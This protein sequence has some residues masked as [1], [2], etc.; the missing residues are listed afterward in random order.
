MALLL[1]EQ[2]RDIESSKRALLG[3]QYYY[4][5]AALSKS[6]A[7]HQE[8]GRRLLLGELSLE[9]VLTHLEKRV[10]EE[11]THLLQVA[12]KFDSTLLRAPI[13]WQQSALFPYQL[14]KQWQELVGQDLTVE[15]NLSL[16]MQLLLNLRALSTLVADHS[17]LVLGDDLVS[18]YLSRIIFI[19]IPTLQIQLIDTLEHSTVFIKNSLENIGLSLQRASQSRIDL[20]KELELKRAIAGAEEQLIE[21]V[22]RLLS[23]RGT[24]IEALSQSALFAKLSSHQLE[25]FLSKDLYALQ[26]KRGYSVLSITLMTLIAFFCAFVFFKTALFSLKGLVEAAEQLAKGDLNTRVDEQNSEITQVGRALNKM[27]LSIGQVLTYLQNAGLQIRSSTLEIAAAAKEQEVTILQQES[28]TRQIADHAK[29]ISDTASAFAR[30]IHEVTSSG[31]ESSAL[32]STGN[33]GLFMLKE[34]M[35]QMVDAAANIA[36]RLSSLNEKAEVITG[37]ITTITQVAD[38]TNLLSLNAA[39]EAQKLGVNGASFKV[40]ATEIRRLADQTAYATLDIEKVVQEM[41]SAVTSSVEGVAR[42]SQDI[43]QGVRQAG[44]ISDLLTKIIAQVEQQTRSFKSVHQQVERQSYDAQL[45]THSI[46]ELS[47]AAQKSTLSI[48]QFHSVL[49]HLGDATKDLQSTVLR[50]Q[51]FSD[52]NL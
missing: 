48:R 47:R 19:E 23:Q 42:F 16:H 52:Q 37:V 17:S 8:V 5:I 32:A 31:K 46:E 25:R 28:A 35:Q 11:F 1:K 44:A 10:D 7:E 22:D 51:N 2:G 4:P 9:S 29:N 6:I 33:E 15:S 24:K 30:H 26:A 3:L 39:I 27:A 43:Q 36:G 18:Y 20:H 13:E 21:A 14:Q 40:I 49:D 34:I 50:L 38:R 45:I 41:V 12:E